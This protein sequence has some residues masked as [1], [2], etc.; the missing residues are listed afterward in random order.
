MSRDRPND[1]VSASDEMGEPISLGV[2]EGEKGNSCRER[3]RPADA[4]GRG[5]EEGP[6]TPEEWLPSWTID[7]I[8]VRNTS[9]RAMESL[10]AEAT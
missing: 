7:T 1:C 2:S 8:Q 10:P 6:L 4:R 9:T 3:G 5:R